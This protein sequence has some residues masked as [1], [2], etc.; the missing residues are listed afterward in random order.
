M[1]TSDLQNE[2]DPDRREDSARGLDG[3]VKPNAVLLFPSIAALPNG[4]RTPWLR[5][6]WAVT[7]CGSPEEIPEAM[8]R[9][10][11]VQGLI[12][13]PWQ[14]KRDGSSAAEM[15]RGLADVIASL[16]SPQEAVPTGSA[17]PGGMAR[18]SDFLSHLTDVIVMPEDACC[19]LMA[20]RIDQFADL[21]SRLDRGAIFDLEERI[22]AR[23]AALLD[24]DDPFT[25]WL[26]FGFGVLARGENGE[27][28]RALAERIC[29]GVAAESFLVGGELTRLTVSIGLALPPRGKVPDGA[30]RWFAAAHAAQAIA[31]R[32]GGNR[33]EGVLTREFEPI[34]AERV[35]IIREWV[36]DAK[37]G[38]NVMIEFQPVLPLHDDAVD[39]YS[40]HAK[41]R[42]YRAPLGGVYRHEY[43]RLA[44]EAGAMV[45]IDRMSLFG[46]FEALEQE[47]AR[48][49][50]TRL[51][52]P[53]DFDSI[54]GVP[55][56]WLQAELRRHTHL[57]DGLILE[58]EASDKLTA[59]HSIERIAQLRE[60]GVRIGLS[61]PQG[62]LER[63]PT[64]SALPVDILRLQA[65]T[66]D[67]LPPDQFR[68]CLAPWQEQG[69]QLIVD[70][71]E[72][73]SDIAHFTGLGVDY[74][75]GQA[76]AAI[77]PRL[78]FEFADYP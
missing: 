67:A 26:D 78:D 34:P 21:V 77:G 58:L 41:L 59:P 16:G 53:V 42:D 39:L 3:S 2:S 18:R 55:W 10:E 70:G 61:D 9:T 57:A 48:G 65:T 44:R 17:L 23:F 19:V 40:V 38:E 64:W 71:V 68:E 13:S 69:R 74:L 66:V 62:G 12:A 33:Q 49:R 14:G 30:Q 20:I 47:R 32:H 36:Q 37:S 72:K 8:L 27:Q 5:A 76:L 46:A 7:T 43:L 25:I 56:R 60:L 45:M 6:G 54:D 50:L 73:A 75:R 24:H 52:V 28:I 29:S 31:F 22:A 63:I 4:W 51:L 11:A 15:A 35:L 1:A